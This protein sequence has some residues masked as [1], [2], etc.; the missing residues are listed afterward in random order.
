MTTRL[1]DRQAVIYQL[2]VDAGV[3]GLRFGELVKQ[4]GGKIQSV[5]ELE[6]DVRTLKDR[7]HIRQVRRFLPYFVDATC[8]T[9]ELR[10]TELN[11][12]VRCI[13]LLRDCPGGL[14]LDVLCTELGASRVVVSSI[15]AA[16]V[17]TGR[18]ATITLPEAH[19]GGPGYA[20]AKPQAWEVFSDGRAMLQLQGQRYR[21]TWDG[22]S[23]LLPEDVTRSMFRHM[24]TLAGLHASQHLQPGEGGAA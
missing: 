9:P 17:D 4:L 16:D 11:L 23:L 21:I 7:K 2:I 12:H 8:V 19:G 6:R 15:L 18:V 13:E 20:L 1:V 24:D 5:R 14:G 10:R 3:D 22:N